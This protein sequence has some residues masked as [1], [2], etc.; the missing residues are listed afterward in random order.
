MVFAIN[1]HLMFNIARPPAIDSP[2]RMYISLPNVMA[3][4][5]TANFDL[6]KATLDGRRL[7]DFDRVVYIQQRGKNVMICLGGQDGNA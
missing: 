3:E 1:D 4:D 7:N 6:E 2:K 5:V